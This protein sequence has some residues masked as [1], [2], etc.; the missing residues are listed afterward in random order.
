M[1]ISIIVI[2]H[3]K[4]NIRQDI[5]ESNEKL[6]VFEGIK[7]F[8][9]TQEEE[10]VWKQL[11]GDV[12]RP[13]SQ[14]LLFSSLIGTGVQIGKTFLSTLVFICLG[15]LE[16]RE[17]G[18][19]A[20]TITFFFTFMAGFA[21]YYSAKIYKVFNGLEWIKCALITATV[22]PVITFLIICGIHRL[23]ALEESSNAINIWTE[24]AIIAL[25]AGVLIP[26]TLLGGFCGFK[27]QTIQDSCKYSYTPKPIPDQ[28]IHP[29][30]LCLCGG[31][32]PFG[33]IFIELGFLMNSVWRHSFYYFYVFFFVVLVILVVISS[34]I[35]IIITYFQLSNGDHRIW[36]TS[37]FGTGSIGAYIFCYSIYYFLVELEIRRFTSIM[38]YF[39][40]MF[41]VSLTFSILCGTVGFLSSYRFVKKIY[42][43]VPSEDVSVEIQPIKYVQYENNEN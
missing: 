37:F 16:H 27:K 26:F 8:E 43:D 12:F 31:L 34:Q 39:G 33:T 20:F 42:S 3:I 23:L 14:T 9:D 4:G 38:L 5:R 41:I 22:Y 6:K 25:W 19:L 2:C 24:L 29:I 28:P 17:R 35:S 15:F 10:K 7:D 11:S 32:I 30:V 36:W 13:P 18:S 40:V 1:I 21:G